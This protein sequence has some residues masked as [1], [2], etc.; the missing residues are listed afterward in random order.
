MRRRWSSARSGVR[1]ELLQQV[2]HLVPERELG[3]YADGIGVPQPRLQ[4]GDVQR[5]LRRL[6]TAAG[7]R[8]ARRLNGGGWGGN[9]C[10]RFGGRRGGLGALRLVE[11][12]AGAPATGSTPIA[13]P[14]A[15]TV[16]PGSAGGGATER[17]GY[18]YGPGGSAATTPSGFGP[19]KD[20]SMNTVR[21]IAP[22]GA[23]S[24]PAQPATRAK[25]SIP[26]VRV[27]VHLFG[28]VFGPGAA[29]L[30]PCRK[31]FIH[32][33]LPS[34]LPGEL[35]SPF[36]GPQAKQALPFPVLCGRRVFGRIRRLPGYCVRMGGL[37]VKAWGGSA[38]HM[39][40]LSPRRDA[41]CSVANRLGIDPV[42]QRIG[43]R[44]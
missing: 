14:L 30:P 2:I 37:M 42:R 28:R 7:P 5:R 29:H 11:G 23:S 35:I 22:G 44:A 20:G 9:L 6:G 15:S 12:G 27:G 24:T 39:E 43:I 17:S 41:V 18:G 40:N 21:A 19:A 3:E 36:P 25:Q 8:L 26:N 1:A 13:T 38:S 10:R 31:F 16:L 4:G 34:A 32:R 33:V